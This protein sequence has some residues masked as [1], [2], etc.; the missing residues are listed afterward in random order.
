MPPPTKKTLKK[1]MYY[2]YECPT[3]G[4]KSGVGNWKEKLFEDYL[5]HQVDEHW[6]DPIIRKE[7]R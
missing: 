7:K 5:N 4:W 6:V 3:C 1:Q 2:V